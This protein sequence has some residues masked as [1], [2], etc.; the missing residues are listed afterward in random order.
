MGLNIKGKINGLVAKTATKV[1]ISWVLGII[2]GAAKGDYGPVWKARYDTASELAPWTG[3]GFCVITVALVASGQTELAGY[4]GVATGVL[5]AAGIVNA[6]YLS[7]M[8]RALK[9]S[10]V[11]QKLV[12]WAP[13]TTLL[14]TTLWAG[15]EACTDPQCAKERLWVGILAAVAA[16]FGLVDAAWQAKPPKPTLPPTYPPIGKAA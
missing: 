15:L 5:V 16:K 11:Y 4:V 9:D 13:T 12:S 1:G 10:P 3:F 7:E 6:A 8:P 14:L 2:K